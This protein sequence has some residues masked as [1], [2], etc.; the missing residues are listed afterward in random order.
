MTAPTGRA[1]RSAAIRALGGERNAI[2]AEQ[3]R[4]LGNSDRVIARI[5]RVDREAVARWF[6][7]QDELV[8]HD[9]LN[10]AA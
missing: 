10:G 2:R 9:D 5:L 6:E 4:A 1:Q 3:L 7:L 8:R